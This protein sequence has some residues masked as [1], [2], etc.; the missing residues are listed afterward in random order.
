MT[1]ATGRPRV[2]R[3]LAPVVPPRPRLEDMVVSL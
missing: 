3:N 1:A 2:M